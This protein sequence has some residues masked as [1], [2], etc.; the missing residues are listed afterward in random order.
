MEDELDPFDFIL[1]ERLGMTVKAMRD[2]M[3]NNEY[4]QWRA[5]HVYRAAQVELAT[6]GMR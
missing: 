5:F 1:A 2:T 6:K 3:P 4:L